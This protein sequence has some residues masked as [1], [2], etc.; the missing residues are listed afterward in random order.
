[1]LICVYYNTKPIQSQLILVS[2]YMFY[3]TKTPDYIPEHELEKMLTFYRLI[4]SPKCR[5]G[6][7]FC[8]R[9]EWAVPRLYWCW[10]N[11]VAEAYLRRY[12]IKKPSD[13]TQQASHIDTDQ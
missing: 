5:L 11:D 2:N 8:T 1:M 3:T 6:E 10:D 12:F 4:E 9:Y 13:C 7:W